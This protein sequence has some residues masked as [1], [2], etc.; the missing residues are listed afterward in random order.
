MAWA[1]IDDKFW[2]H[3][4]VMRA[5]Q[6]DPAAI[7]LWTMALTQA[8]ETESDGWIDPEW[9]EVIM[10]DAER[11]ERLVAVLIDAGLWREFGDGWEFHDYHDFQPAKSHL[12][13]VREMRRINGSKGGK[14]SGEVRAA[15]SNEANAK[16][17]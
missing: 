10:P 9:L 6:R 13:H 1:K 3:K 7:G 14:R 8:N 2:H 16:Q 12:E 11:R 4:K 17:A 5:W 15:R